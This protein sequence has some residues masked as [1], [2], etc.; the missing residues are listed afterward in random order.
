VVALDREGG[1]VGIVSIP[2][3]LWVDIPGYP[4]G[5]QRINAVDY[6]GE[7]L[8]V[9]GGGPALAAQVISET[10]GIPTQ[11]YV[12][13]HLNGLVRLVDALGGVK[14][15]L[16][17]PLYEATPKD[18]TMTEYVPWSLPAG[19]NWLDG[20]TARK[21]VTYRSVTSDFGRSSRQQQM[22]W[23]LRNRALE[24]DLLP[25][26]PELLGALSDLYTTDLNLIDIARL[27]QFGAGLGPSDVHGFQIG[28]SMLSETVTANGEWVLTLSDP[29]ALAAEK[30]K[31]FL[32]KPLEKLGKNESGKECP[33]PPQ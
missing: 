28:M 17:C 3:D 26:L 10:L 9:P 8:E 16:D 31:L 2:R 22:I 21:F 18:A 32:H 15:T 6:I 5:Q 24:I 7:K 14:V 30:E 20:D 25:R 33:P 4:Q 29:A 11:H 12:R 23:A 19:E 13:I 1:Q 27:A